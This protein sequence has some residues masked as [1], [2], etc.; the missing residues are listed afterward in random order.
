MSQFENV[1][2]PFKMWGNRQILTG[3]QM[4]QYPWIADFVKRFPACFEQCTY[5]DIVIFY[6]DG[7]APK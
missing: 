4:V 5:R 7:D 6:P 3:L 2:I 1:A